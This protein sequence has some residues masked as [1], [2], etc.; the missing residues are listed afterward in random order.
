MTDSD[1]AP[2]FSEAAHL[3]AANEKVVNLMRQAFDSEVDRFLDAVLELMQEGQPVEEKGKANRTWW[4]AADATRDAYPY[5][6]FSARQ[7]SLVVSKTLDVYGYVQNGDSG[8]TQ[9]LKDELA[10]M[11]LPSSCKEQKPPGST[12]VL[13]FSVDL[14]GFGD[15]AREYAACLLDVL[16]AMSA[17]SRKLQA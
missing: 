15:P 10:Q 11:S 13:A 8:A 4:L 9:V 14:S 3:Y 6:W 17:A 7:A 2:L 5:L 16:G 1:E 12:C